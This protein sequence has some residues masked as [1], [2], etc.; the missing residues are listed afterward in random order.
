MAAG[1]ALG[2]GY[3]FGPAFGDDIPVLMK[4]GGQF[5]WAPGEWTD[6]TSMAVP[7]LEAAE[8]AVASGEALVDHLDRV[9]RSWFDWAR[10]ARDVGV[11]TRAVLGAAAREGVVSA[12]Q[13]SAAS[14][15]HLARTGRA[16]GNGSLMRTAP[17]ALAHVG[18]AAAIADA[19]RRVSDLTHA[20]TDA[21]DACVLWCLAIDHGVRT[22][23][24]GMAAGLAMLPAPRRDVWAQRI[25]DAESAP[26]V[27][28]GHNGWVVHA[29]QAAWSAIHATRGHDEQLRVA[30][31]MCVRA[32]GDTDTVACIAGQLL[33][34]VHGAGGVPREWVALLHGWPGMTGSELA[35]RARGLVSTTCES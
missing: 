33:G 17:V 12:A 7:L 32:G 35:D 21:G 16:A 26:P 8:R 4:G 6:D 13:L 27:S 31:E 20:E 30:L 29:F 3:E 28:F 9:A 25:E 14:R 10:S 1:D 19:A 2:A 18:D 15:E 11:Q 34:A 22:G 24:L 5:D 23:G